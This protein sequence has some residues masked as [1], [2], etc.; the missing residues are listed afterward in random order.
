M[1]SATATLIS[2][3]SER[4][5]TL[6]QSGDLDEALHAATASVDKTQQVLDGDLD[7]IDA[8]ATALERRGDI[9]RELGNLEAACEDYRQAIDQLDHRPDCL[10]QLGRLHAG[11]GSAKDSM[12]NAEG[13][14]RH[15]EMAIEAFE[16]H[17]PPLLLDV[18]GLANNLGFVK[19][20]AGDLDAAESHFLRS[21][22]IL[23]AQLG[24]DHEITA[25]VSNNLG[26]LYQAAGFHEQAR[27]MHMMALETRRTLLGESHPDTAQSHNNLALALLNTGDRSWARRHFEKALASYESL[28]PE[29]SADLEAVASNYCDF[30]R[31]EGEA[32]LADVIAGR[33][34]DV[35]GEPVA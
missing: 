10:G 35:V 26:A 31:T 22:E 6:R 17:E 25:S 15:W 20:A 8:F 30:L 33:V 23:H 9:H 1:D 28:G 12:G 19:K 11:M 13:A 29:Y 14:A 16:K 24:Q 32:T 18:A 21:L 7:S 27:E 2:I 3:L 34:R 4:V 5:E